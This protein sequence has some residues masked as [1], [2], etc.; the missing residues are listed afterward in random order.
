MYRTAILDYVHRLAS[1]F[2]NITAMSLTLTPVTNASLHQK[3]FFP[4]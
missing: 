3:T 2:E 1:E 4:H